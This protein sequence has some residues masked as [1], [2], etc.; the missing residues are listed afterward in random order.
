M[1]VPDLKYQTLIKTFSCLSWMVRGPTAKS[2]NW[3]IRGPEDSI[4]CCV[5][6]MLYYICVNNILNKF[7][8]VNNNNNN[9]NKR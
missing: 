8:K 4:P 5:I 6:C 9:N 2:K 3:E 7:T 1:R